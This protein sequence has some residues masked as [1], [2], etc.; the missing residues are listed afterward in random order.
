M[1][2]H[3]GTISQVIGPVLD[4]EF[5]KDQIP[6]IYNAIAVAKGDETIIAEVEHQISETQVRCVAMTSTQ[7]IKRGMKATDTGKPISMPVGEKA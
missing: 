2:Q 1:A 5:D 7:G 4:I 6:A 3:Q